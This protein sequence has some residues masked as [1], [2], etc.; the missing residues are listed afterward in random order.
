MKKL[1]L[2]SVAIAALAVSPAMAAD[3][4]ARGPVYKAAA[5][6]AV[7]AYNW[8]GCYIGGQVGYQWGDDHTR[9]TV[10]A[11]GAFTG[12][13]Q[14]FTTNGVVGGG[15]VGCNVQSSSIVFGVEGDLEWTGV[16]GGYRLANGNGTDF[17]QKWQGSVR[18]RLGFAADRW[19]FYVTGGLAF[20]RFEYTYVDGPPPVISETFSTTRTGWTFGGGI[21][22]AFASNWTGRVEYRYTDY[23]S[24]SNNSVVAFPGFTYT[25]DPQFHTVRVGLSYKF[26]GGPV[27]ARY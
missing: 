15:H 11:T 24:L 3:I 1:L 10:T 21:E 25:H 14:S 23:G 27:V 26:G 18:G 16:D 12:F 20:S 9:E 6:V 22:H 5:P 7:A 17:D 4:P 2:G 19:L 8:G 13:D